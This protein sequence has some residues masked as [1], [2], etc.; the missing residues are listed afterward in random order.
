MGYSSILKQILTMGDIADYLNVCPS[1]SV[2]DWRT[3]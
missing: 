1:L 2:G 3:R